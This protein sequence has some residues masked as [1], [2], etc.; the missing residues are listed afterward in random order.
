MLAVQAVVEEKEVYKV[1]RLSKQ[2]GARDV[3]V[4]PIERV[5]P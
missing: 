3:L 1:I 5:V 2:A 4:L